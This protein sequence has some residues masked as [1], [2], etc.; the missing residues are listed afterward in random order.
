MSKSVFSAKVEE[1]LSVELK[2]FLA[3]NYDTQ[4]MGLIEM[5]QIAKA[6]AGHDELKAPYNR[7]IIAIKSIQT[8]F[9]EVSDIFQSEK[10]KHGEE[11]ETAKTDQTE[12]IEEQKKLLS[13]QEEKYAA[14]ENKFKELEERNLILTNSI[15]KTSKERDEL[16]KVQEK[17]DERFKKMEDNV[18]NRLNSFLEQLKEQNESKGSQDD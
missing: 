4:E 3:E 7:F 10:I 13:T 12:R 11:I 15:S 17:Q 2:E 5:L 1:E 6:F 18:E 8:V 14:L 9:T 16:I